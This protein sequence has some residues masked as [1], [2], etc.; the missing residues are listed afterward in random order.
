MRGGIW[1]ENEPEAAP[2]PERPYTGTDAHDEFA[3]RWKVYW[4]TYLDG[5]YI[6][7][8]ERNAENPAHY[9]RKTPAE[10]RDAVREHEAARTA[11]R[12]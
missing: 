8:E 12:P 3:D 9:A 2:E 5:P 7:A 4:Q 1:A 11:R 10:L 6:V